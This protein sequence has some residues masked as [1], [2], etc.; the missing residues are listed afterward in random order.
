VTF[1]VIP[2]DDVTFF[3]LE[4]LPKATILGGM[5]SHARHI[6]LR[7]VA[8][9]LI[10]AHLH[11]GA[12]RRF[13]LD[14]NPFLGWRV[15]LVVT[16]EGRT[17]CEGHSGKHRGSIFSKNNVLEPP[18]S[19]QCSGSV[20]SGAHHSAHAVSFH[21]LALPLVVSPTGRTCCEGHSNKLVGSTFEMTDVSEPPG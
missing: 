12:N 9:P 11:P 3:F 14:A 21:G 17:C 8:M 2:D 19:P 13:L 6:I 20:R 10:L 5:L 15:H 4:C 18:G 16:R 7:G 1:E